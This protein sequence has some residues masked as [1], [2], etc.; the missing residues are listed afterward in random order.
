MR[1]LYGAHTCGPPW[2]SVSPRQAL[3]AVCHCI[4]QVVG[5]QASCFAVDA[6]VLQTDTCCGTTPGFMWVL[7]IRIQLFFML[8]QHVCSPHWAASP[9]LCCFFLLWFHLWY[10]WNDHIFLYSY[11]YWDGVR[12]RSVQNCVSWWRWDESCAVGINSYWAFTVSKTQHTC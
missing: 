11:A 9:A 10:F 2:V 4:H 3:L 6:L 5:P 1:D 8:A 12:S 7:G